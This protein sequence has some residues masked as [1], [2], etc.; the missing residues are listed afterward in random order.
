MSNAAPTSFS[1]ANTITGNLTGE[2]NASLS[3]VS[4]REDL[5]LRYFLSQE[6]RDANL[7]FKAPR[8][9]DAGFD[10]PSLSAVEIKPGTFQAVRTGIHLAIPLGYVGIVRDRSSVALRGG[11]CT[12]GVIDA[13]Y[14]GEVKVVIHNLG[15]EPL[16][17]AKGDRI[18]QIILLPHYGTHDTQMSTVQVEALEGL[19]T[20]ERAAGGFGSTG[21]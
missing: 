3:N 13:S 8:L 5:E 18:A 20:T 14:R 11:A 7:Q 21:R 12:A 6:A 17:F 1:S 10:L 9:G 15:P 19:G 4:T 16:T 2:L